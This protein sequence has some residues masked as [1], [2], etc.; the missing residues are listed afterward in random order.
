MKR[1]VAFSALALATSAFADPLVAPPAL[2]DT[3]LPDA[4][5][6]A[7]A[8]TLMGEIRCLVCQGQSVADSDAELAG[9]MRAMIRQRV[10]AGEANQTIRQWLI[11]HYGAWIAFRPPLTPATWLLWS[12][13]LLLLGGGG[14]MAASRFR[15]RAR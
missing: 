12:A 7:R 14:V 13:P 2:A 11:A 8:E 10:A 3:Q 6:E 9:D 1:M 15:R 4:A 5:Q